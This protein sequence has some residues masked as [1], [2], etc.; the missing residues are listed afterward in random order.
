M[1][2]FLQLRLWW[3]RGGAG[4][5]LAVVLAGAIVIA[6]AAW[7]LVPTGSDQP[8]AS[9]NL[10]ATAGSPGAAGSST[11][12]TVAGA[13]G[14][15]G[16]TG[17]SVPG[18]PSAGGASGGAAGGAA[19]SAGGGGVG[20]ASQGGATAGPNT[21]C[22]SVPKGTAGV[23]DRTILLDVA[24]LDLAGPIGNGAVS[25]A[26]ADD[27]QKVAQAVIAD[28]N[29]RGGVACRQLTAK[30]YKVNPISPDSG[31]AA[32]LQIVQ[33]RPALAIDA[34]GLVYGNAYNCVPQQKVP[35]LTFMNPLPSELARFAPYLGSPSADLG[36][37][38]RD[39]VYGMKEQGLFDPAKGFKKLGLLEEQCAPEAMK[40]FEDTL[41]KVG[42][43]SAQ[44]SKY[45]FACPANG[46][47]SP[48]DMAQAVSQHRIAGASLVVPLTGG[49]SFK[50][51][52]ETAE[53]QGYR[54]KYAITDYQGMPITSTSNLKP[55]PDNFDGAIGISTGTYGIDTTP[56]A[57]LDAGTKR[58]Q[59]IVVKAGLPPSAVFGGGG[60]VCGSLWIAEAALAHARALSPDG[61]LP[62]LY[63]AGSVQLAYPVPDATF[64]PGKLHGGDTYA[65][66][67]FH[68]DCTC[69]RIVGPRTPSHA[70]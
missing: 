54:P 39:A 20:A 57:G 19:G 69:W 65:P 64:A 1:T 7:L 9:T 6:L 62:G 15:G 38:M 48:S 10:Q 32:C 43:T 55:N 36:T 35:T 22:P 60:T 25:Q 50:A 30:Y 68:K 59:A 14:A 41:A 34:G 51:Y 26:S 58:C 28:V 46:F 56:G 70:S 61:I 13:P 49:G 40:I 53:R 67:Q 2:P 18:A 47:A 37:V 63:G 66:I 21:N 17:A 45:S 31:H 44:I 27:M 29:A 23:A 5:R 12:G 8:A 4:E 52:S 11:Q 16:A 33:D 24:L 3:R 42:V